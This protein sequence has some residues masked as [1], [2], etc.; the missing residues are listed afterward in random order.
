MSAIGFILIGFGALTIWSGFSG[1]IIFDVLRSFLG[2]PTPNR[3][4]SGALA[5][6][7]NRPVAA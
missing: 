5:P 7:T 6:S 3:D 2:A 1:V 4:V